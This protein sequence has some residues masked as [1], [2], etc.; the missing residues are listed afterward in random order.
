L[1]YDNPTLIVQ[2]TAL[3]TQEQYKS[4][5]ICEDKLK[6]KTTHI[7]SISYMTLT[8]VIFL[9]NIFKTKYI[10][11]KTANAVCGK[12]TDQKPN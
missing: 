3:M 10:D 2:E 6:S 5:K 1:R 12:K 11:K 9:I 7:D 4:V 8:I